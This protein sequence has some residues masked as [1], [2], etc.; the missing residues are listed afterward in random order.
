MSNFIHSLKHASVRQLA[1]ACFS[2]PLIA[3]FSGLAA[4]VTAPVFEL[5]EDRRRRLQALDQQPEP[6][7]AYMRSHCKSPRLGLRFESYWHYFLETDPEV[8]LIAHNLPVR[9]EGR[10][11]GEFDVL[12]FCHQ[13][14]TTIHLE[15]AIKFFMATGLTLKTNNLLSVWLGPNSRDRLDIKWRRMRSHQ[16]ALSETPAAQRALSQLG[17]SSVAKEVSIKGWL[18]HQRSDEALHPAI[19]PAHQRGSWLYRRDFLAREEPG[20]WHYLPK[21]EWLG[22]FEQAEMIGER[23]LALC[24]HRPVMLLNRDGERLMVAPDHWPASISE[25]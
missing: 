15:L 12:Y 6:L 14:Q 24:T 17:I 21:P 11:L 3:D 5:H 10:T 25:D 2:E 16:L 13:R 18:F 22:D 7:L 20:N 9:E 19:N 1:W 4:K 23:A 8:D